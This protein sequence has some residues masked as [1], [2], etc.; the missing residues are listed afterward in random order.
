M[1][2]DCII[3][4]G[5]SRI[6]KDRLFDCSDPYQI[7]VCD[8]CGMIVPSTTECLACKKDNVTTCNIPYASKLVL[9]ELMSMGIKISIKPGR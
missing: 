5:A 2:R 4:H 9:S 8:H 7:I 3:A 6:L 1:E